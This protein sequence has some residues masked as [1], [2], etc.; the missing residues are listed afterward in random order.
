MNRLVFIIMV[1]QTIVY[2]LW[3]AFSYSIVDARN[4]TVKNFGAMT[5]YL[6]SYA[7]L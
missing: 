2:F 3:H 1:F 6:Y 5:V 7:V 4:P